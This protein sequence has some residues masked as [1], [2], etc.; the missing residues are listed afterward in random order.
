M[1]DEGGF[2]VVIGNPPWGA[3]FDKL[4]KSYIVKQYPLV[5]TK[6]KDSYFYF[7]SRA[8]RILHN[9]GYLGFIIPNTWLLINNAKEFRRELLLWDIREIIDHGDGVFEQ[10]IAESATLILVKKK[11]NNSCRA[12][13]MRRGKVLVDHMVNKELWINDIYSRIIIDMTP[14]VKKLFDKLRNTSEPFEK[15]CSIIWGIKPYQVGYGIP[16]Q[17]RE[18]L[19]KRVYHAAVKKGKE[20]KPLIVGSNVDRYKTHF[21]GNLF[22]KYGTWLMYPSNESLMLHPKILMRQT[23]DILRAG[24]DDQGYYCQN[25]V[26]IIHS[27]EIDLKYLLGLLNSKLIG[28]VYKMGNPQTKKVFAEIKPSVIKQIPIRTVDLANPIEKTLHDDLVALVDVMLNLNKKIQTA[29]GSRKGQIQQQIEKTNKEID[30]I[31]YKLY[32][33]TEEERKII[34][35]KR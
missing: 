20:W 21:P 8:L 31:V 2:D 26:F 19:K 3:E 12:V 15:R 30:D 35:S 27:S 11:T 23:S 5:P 25:S 28:Y 33:I 22:I 14:S 6:T 17:T 24:Y 32:G 7:I 13:R 4:R 34:E 10:A 16:P 1:V 29:R 9:S 18:M